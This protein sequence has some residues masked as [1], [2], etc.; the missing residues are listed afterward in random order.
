MPESLC[1]STWYQPISGS[2]GAF[3][4]APVEQAERLGAETDAE[5]R[6]IATLR[7]GDEFHLATE[8]RL[9][10]LFVVDRTLRSEDH[11]DVVA[12]E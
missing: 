6:D 8:P 12:V 11:E 7:V 10:D 3:D 4:D 2:L 5:D 1:P 9:F